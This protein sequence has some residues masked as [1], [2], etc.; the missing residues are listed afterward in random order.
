MIHRYFLRLVAT[1]CF[2]V[3][4]AAQASAADLTKVKMG[5]YTGITDAP[6]FVADAKGFFK[7]NGLD[8]EMIPFSSG[9]AMVSSLLSGSTPFV[10]GGG[11]LVTFPQVAKGFKIR[12]VINVWK[13][14]YLSLIGLASLATPNAGKPY[15]APIVDLRGKRIGVIALGSHVAAVVERM[16][17]DAGL[18][19]GQD[20]TLIGV[21]SG[22]TA[23][24]AF[25]AKTIDAY[26][27]LPPMTQTLDAMEPG[28]YKEI[29][30]ANQFPPHLKWL[31]TTHIATTQDYAE[32]NPQVVQAFCRAVRQSMEWVNVPENFQSALAAIEK[33]LPGY[34]PGVLAASLKA[35]LPHMAVGEGQT[36]LFTPENMSNANELLINKGIINQPITSYALTPCQ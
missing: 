28:S 5:Y 1:L 6:F 16:L 12:G 15:P 29:L 20:V 34:P 33:R 27:S 8:V 23:I 2:V 24:A 19:I 32:K 10:D 7:S 3:L 30:P 22:P 11:P 25:N 36:G 26:I 9:P 17:K 35:M 13:D 14:N 4:T 21:G 18:S 31:F